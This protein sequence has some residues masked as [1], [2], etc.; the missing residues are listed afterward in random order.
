MEENTRKQFK[1]SDEI[2]AKLE[3]RF[4][5]WFLDTVM[6]IVLSLILITIVATI[7]ESYKNKTIALYL[8]TNPI[9]QF[10]FVTITRLFYYISF[11]TLYGRTIGKFV[12]QTIV[13]DENG[14]PPTHE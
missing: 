1:V 7:A 9:G 3:Q 2:A 10:T 4:I 12:T 14:D 11:E 13:V 5:N 6:L 8:L